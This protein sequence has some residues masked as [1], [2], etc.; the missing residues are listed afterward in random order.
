M[1]AQ[2][3]LDIDLSSEDEFGGAMN[4]TNAAHT[5][6]HHDPKPFSQ[7]VRRMDFSPTP[8]PPPPGSD[9]YSAAE[10]LT[11]VG[12]ASAPAA[13]AA[14][15][16]TIAPA[17]PRNPANGAD[18]ASENGFAKEGSVESAGASARQASSPAVGASS[19][20]SARSR[21]S[22]WVHFTRD[23]DYATNRRGRCV[24]CHNYYSCSSGS[25]GNMWRHIK[26]SHPEKAAQ[27][28]P[29]ATHGAHAHATPQPQQ[30]TDATLSSID[31]RSRKRQASL[32]SPVNDHHPSAPASAR[33]QAPPPFGS[34]PQQQLYR[35]A[36]EATP[37]PE[38][39]S[40]SADAPG[41]STESLAQALRLLLS[42]TGRSVGAAPAPQSLL[43]TLLESRAGAHADEGASA[44]AQP[45]APAASSAAAVDPD[46]VARFVEAVGNA[47]RANAEAARPAASR[48]QQTLD[49]YTGFMV[50]D[51]VSVEKMLSPGMQHLVAGLGQGAPPPAAADLV[52]ELTRQRDAAAAELRARLDAV[53][54]RVSVSIGSACIAGSLHSLAVYA[55]WVDAAFQRHDALLD[56]RCV[57]GAPTSGDIIAVFEAT[58]SHY[59]LF[60]KL[61]TVTTTYTREFVEFLNQAETICHAR[62]GAFDLG[63]NQATCIV[64][65]LLD[66]K[67]K[68]LS[69]LG[70]ADAPPSDPPT[71]LARL[72]AALHALRTPGADSGRQLA[73]V[74]RA[75]AISPSALEYD[76][77][78][79]WGSTVALLDAVLA[80]RADLAVLVGDALGPADW[81]A[82]AQTRVLLRILDLAFSGLAALPAEFVPIV[83]LVPLYDTL[84]DNLHGF[85]LSPALHAD[86]RRA[87][88]ALR[89]YLAQC[90][91]FQASP[92]FRLA[93][94]FDPR[95]K[96]SYYADHG[97]DEAWIR[98][99]MREART[100]LSDYVAP[101]PSPAVAD[102]PSPSFVGPHSDDVDTQTEAFVQLGSPAVAAQHI[103]D[104]NARIFRRALAAGRWELDEYMA[105]PLASPSTP[106]L[107]WWRLHHAAFPGLAKLAREYLAIAA[108]SDSSAALLRKTGR[109]D[110]SLLAGLDKKLVATYICLH[111]WKRSQA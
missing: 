49:A 2:S 105:A 66:A 18:D 70:A 56:C 100:I 23:P 25:T 36:E 41:A 69:A 79:P 89:E 90:H 76:A 96:A 10:A 40:A 1:N 94:L 110:F 20:P 95:L 27:A 58:L 46:S 15:T 32:S 65:S 3:D 33:S 21:T 104:G 103:A 39:A 11:A 52:A 24:Y 53:D 45:A 64:S 61:A 19:T 106:V 71:P 93:P 101:T 59:G 109:P 67:D 98:R 81:L 31:N 86:V 92:V 63:R 84:V 54:S 75:R 91:P 4:D 51:L 17:A 77:A 87:A 111:H 47:V 107:A 55:H 62:G 28:A 34:L 30:R 102:A 37:V 74:C 43:T 8:S 26:R 6:T 108:A 60:T 83:D 82:L 72:R 16:T 48:A 22:I 80:A 97:L 9:A 12:A 99:V 35:H 73:D 44:P 42:V 88:D 13:A 7:N 68:L 57:D 38:H 85:L 29:L 14:A 50:R 5:H 78:R